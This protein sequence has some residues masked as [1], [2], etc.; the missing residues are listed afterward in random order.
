MK[1]G[2]IYDQ[3][4]EVAD[5]GIIEFPRLSA[6]YSKNDESLWNIYNG[7]NMYGLFAH[8]IHPDDVLD[9]ERNEGKS[10]TITFRRIR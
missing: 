5:D 7:L 3:E 8:F 10:W 6:G 1:K 2:I 4:F 9:P